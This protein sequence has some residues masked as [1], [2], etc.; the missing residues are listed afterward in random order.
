MTSFAVSDSGGGHFAYFAFD[1]IELDGENLALLPLRERKTRL[2]ALLKNPPVGI[3]YSDHEGGD[4]EVFRWAACKHGLEGIVSKRL[5]R[6]YLPGDRGARSR[7]RPTDNAWGP[8]PDRRRRHCHVWTTPADQGFFCRVARVVGAVMSPAWLCGD[9][10]RSAGPDVVRVIPG[11]IKASRSRSA[12]SA[13]GLGMV[14]AIS[15]I[16]S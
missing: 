4:G 3:A 1:L 16:T 11:P 7:P 15:H 10:M 5:D 12:D 9:K 6:A 13:S 8:S 2:A 14:S